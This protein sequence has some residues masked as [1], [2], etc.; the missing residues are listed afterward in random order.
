MTYMAGLNGEYAIECYPYDGFGGAISFIK[1]ENVYFIGKKEVSNKSCDYL[2]FLNY[3][4]IENSP[5]SIVSDFNA[6]TNNLFLVYSSGGT[7]CF[8]SR[9]ICEG[10]I[11]VG[12]KS[13]A[14]RNMGSNFLP[15]TYNG[16]TVN[17]SGI[18]EIGYSPSFHDLLDFSSENKLMYDRGSPFNYNFYSGTIFNNDDNKFSCL[19]LTDRFT[20]PLPYSTNQYGFTLATAVTPVH[21]CINEH[22]LPYIPDSFSFYNHID[23]KIETRN[24]VKKIGSNTN[25][26]LRDY[27]INKYGVS[28]LPI[29]TG[30]CL[31]D[32]PLPEGVSLACVPDITERGIESTYARRMDTILI[33]QTVR[34]YY[35]NAVFGGRNITSDTGLKSETLQYG[36]VNH[37]SFFEDIIDVSS[38]PMH[39]SLGDSNSQCFTCI[40]NK[41][42]YLGGVVYGSVSRAGLGGSFLGEEGYSKLDLNFYWYPDKYGDIK[43]S[44]VDR[45]RSSEVIFVSQLWSTIS[46]EGL[47]HLFTSPEVWGIDIDPTFVPSRI[48]I[49]NDIS[50]VE[51]NSQIELNNVNLRG[52][53]IKFIN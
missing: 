46:D 53:K 18:K 15:Y 8:Q 23:N 44:V 51:Q 24:V 21:I 16:V 45:Y 41:I 7:A 9:G 10:D 5:I 43:N 2:G 4:K 35:S 26:I 33:D 40:D 28:L 47:R 52:K 36:V 13:G 39:M 31:L 6:S 17:R 27:M 19:S 14:V 42:I 29:D 30:I 37:S 32:S 34:G 11:V 20:L 22:V 50:I 48:K 25:N 1:N 12:A 38:T 49:T 3:F